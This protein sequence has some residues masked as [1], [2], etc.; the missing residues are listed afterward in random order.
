MQQ[1]FLAPLIA[2]ALLAFAV[3][4]T[5]AA[6]TDFEIVAQAGGASPEDTARIV[7][8]DSTGAGEACTI[9]PQDREAALCTQTSPV[10][11]SPA[12]LDDLWSVVQSS[13]FFALDSTYFDT[14]LV[15]GT[16]AE[17]SI[18]GGGT[19]HTVMIQNMSV[20]ALDTVVTVLNAA[21]SP[22][23]R[24]SYLGLP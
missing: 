20:A 9:E 16:W 10:L 24:L 12:V 13:G 1:P 2:A 21:L 14:T 23:Q 6:P 11:L 15:G 8:V 4:A 18:R 5:A 7:V 22:E 19:T 17:V 3:M